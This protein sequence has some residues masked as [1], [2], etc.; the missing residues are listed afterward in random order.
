MYSEDISLDGDTVKRKIII[1]W[2]LIDEAVQN[3]EYWKPG[4]L[5]N[6]FLLE[7]W[8]WASVKYFQENRVQLSS[9]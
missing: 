1:V 5:I 8:V 7:K 4:D 3:V 6:G 2:L 9:K